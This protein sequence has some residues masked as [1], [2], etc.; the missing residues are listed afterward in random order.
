MAKDDKI[1]P[2]EADFDD[3]AK[4]MLTEKIPLPARYAL[5]SGPLPIGGTDLQC[6][7]LDNEIRVL[8]SSSI[9]KA[10]GRSRKGMNSRL[11]IDGTTIP[12]FLAAK[13]L[14]IYINQDV[15]ERTKLIEYRDGNT[16]KSGY[17]AELLGDICE[18]YLSARRSGDLTDSQ[19]KVSR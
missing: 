5:L 16:I 12:P 7:V 1:E 14:K 2:I 6:A 4:S 11:E 18:V 9:F 19:Y 13:S 3:V 8:S 17:N 10:F 15:I